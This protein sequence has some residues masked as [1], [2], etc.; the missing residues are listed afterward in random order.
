[1]N[2]LID[3]SIWSLGLRRKKRPS[4]KENELI[5]EL[6][7]LIQEVRA[8]IIGPIRQEILSGISDQNQYTVLRDRLRAFEDLPLLTSDYETA[9]DFHNLCRRNGIQGSHIDFL[10]CAVAYLN[11]MTI[12][13]TDEDF[14]LYSKH[15]KID[16]HRPRT[17]VTAIE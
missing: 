6:T 13:T 11:R 7:N 12:F 17:E 2:V 9:A 14:T 1:M 8:S 10:I 4:S 3:T 16:L 15:L 5:G